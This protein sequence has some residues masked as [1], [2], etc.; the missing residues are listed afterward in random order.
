MA[1][2]RV[3]IL[4]GGAVLTV[5]AGA[6]TKDT[7]QTRVD[8]KT[9]EWRT[10][11]GDISS[12]RYSP[13]NQITAENFKDLKVAWTWDGASFN[14]VSGR[15][16]PSYMGGKLFTVAGERRSVV[17]IARRYCGR[18]RMIAQALSNCLGAE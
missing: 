5:A 15:S 9:V 6:A 11:G 3:V 8:A 7:T 18:S 16:T 12:T 17:S 1:V 14:A 2:H 4:L 10:Q 13:A